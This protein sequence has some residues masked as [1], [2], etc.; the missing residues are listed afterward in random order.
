MTS[1]ATISFSSGTPRHVVAYVI[2]SCPGGLKWSGLGNVE[3][4]SLSFA[5]SS[6]VIPAFRGP[7]VSN[8]CRHHYFDVN[9]KNLRSRT[10]T[11]FT[12]R[13]QTD[14]YYYYYYYCSTPCSVVG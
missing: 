11:L 2:D 1:C 4:A 14:I 5:F 6:F 13:S 10:L 12:S 8:V 9:V 3:V 7:K